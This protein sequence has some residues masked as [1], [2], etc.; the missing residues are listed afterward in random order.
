M[1]REEGF[2]FPPYTNLK[3]YQAFKKQG[4]G[5]LTI[6]E[7]EIESEADEGII[8]SAEETLVDEDE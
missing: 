5:I 7:D 1:A 4:A 3:G 8:N 6:P 2:E